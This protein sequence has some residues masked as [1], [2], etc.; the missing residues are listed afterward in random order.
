MGKQK[1]NSNY[2]TEK[3]AQVKNEKEK[4]EQVRK[5]KKLLVSI[6]I[7]TVSV[8]LLIGLIVGLGSCYGWFYKNPNSDLEITHH[9]SIKI[10]GYDETL[11]VELYGKAAPTT[12]NKFVS[13]AKNGKYNGTSF[14]KMIED[15]MACGGDY[16]D[17][18]EIGANIKGEFSENNFDN[19]VKHVRGTISMEKTGT[20]N[21]DPSK[22][23]I[24]MDTS[25][26]ITERFDGKYAAFGTVIEGMEI[27]DEIVKNTQ[28][29]ENG[30]VSYAHQPKIESISIHDAH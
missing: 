14:F 7:P 29:G 21:S 25:D 11:H 18:N 22:F 23:F 17:M 6:L 3:R 2:A 16:L 26:E 10:E 4:A 5:K 24:V 27:I 30:D 20:K 19:P 8:L 13:A 9:A 12:V 28:K 15:V 1:K